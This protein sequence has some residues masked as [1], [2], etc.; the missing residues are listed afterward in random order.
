MLAK[1]ESAKKNKE[2]ISIGLLGNAA[3]IIP[4]FVKKNIIPTSPNSSHN[5]IT[6][7]CGCKGISW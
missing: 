6:P 7:L 4:L 5:C 2:P 3:E 1:K